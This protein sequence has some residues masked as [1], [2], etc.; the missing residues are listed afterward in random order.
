MLRNMEIW[1]RKNTPKTPSQ[2]G[3]SL[4]IFLIKI[5]ISTIF[6]KK[7]TPHQQI[8]VGVDTQMIQSNIIFLRSQI[9]K[10]QGL[11][12][13]AM[14]AFRIKGKRDYIAN[15]SLIKYFGKAFGQIVQN[16]FSKSKKCLLSFQRH[17]LEIFLCIPK[18]EKSLAF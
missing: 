14:I 8:G 7:T 13:V 4:R 9:Y 1:K 16:G 10:R 5:K 6:V 2:F 12:R 15:H 18:I 17:I 11:F 3:K